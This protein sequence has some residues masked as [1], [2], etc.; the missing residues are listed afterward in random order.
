MHCWPISL[1]I[2]TALLIAHFIE[3]RKLFDLIRCLL[4]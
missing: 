1:L 2:K 4:R 3:I